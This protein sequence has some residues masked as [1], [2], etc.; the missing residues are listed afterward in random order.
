MPEADQ[1]TSVRTLVFSDLVDSTRLNRLLSDEKWSALVAY[2]DEYTRQLLAH[3]RGEEFNRSDGY[4]MFFPDPLAALRFA[5]AYHGALAKASTHVGLPIKARVGIHHGPVRIKSLKDTPGASTHTQVDGLALSVTA[6]IMGLADGGQ[7][8]MTRA[9]F[10][11]AR[12]LLAAIPKEGVLPQDLQWHAHGEYRLKGLTDQMEVFEAGIPDQAPL[13]APGNTDKGVRVV[14]P[15]EEELLGWRPGPGLALPG[16]NQWI[17]RRKLGQGGFGE[18]W[19]AEHQGLR[20]QHVFKFCFHGERLRGLRREVMLFRALKD[21]LGHQDHVAKVLDWNLEFPPYHVELEYSELGSVAD[22][23]RSLG[24]I[25]RVPLRQRLEVMQDAAEG[26]YA[27]HQAGIIHRD[28]K[29]SNILVMPGPQ[30]SVRGLLSD[31][32]I[33]L[34]EDADELRLRG[35]TVTGTVTPTTG[36]STAGTRMYMAPELDQGAKPSPSTDIYSYGVTLY[37]MVVGDLNRPISHGWEK[38]VESESL[39]EIIT[40]CIDR[41]GQRLVTMLPLLMR[42]KN[43]LAEIRAREAQERSILARLRTVF[44]PIIH[45]YRWVAFL[46]V[47][48]VSLA[49]IDL[50]NYTQGRSSYLSHLWDR[51]FR[52]QLH[53]PGPPITSNQTTPNAAAPATHQATRTPDLQARAVY[54]KVNG[55]RNDAPDCGQRAI[56]CVEINKTGSGRHPVS[57]EFVDNGKPLTRFTGTGDAMINGTF[58]PGAKSSI[59]TVED[60][61]PGVCEICSYGQVVTPISGSNSLEVRVDPTNKLT[62]TNETNNTTAHIYHVP[63]GNYDDIWA[64]GISVEDD[65]LRAQIVVGRKVT[66]EGGLGR[67]F[68]DKL[69]PMNYSLTVNGSA[70]A[71]GS[72]PDRG[73][74]NLSWRVPF[75][76]EREGRYDFVITG[77]H[78][79]GSERNTANNTLKLS[80]LAVPV[81]RVTLASHPAVRTEPSLP[82]PGQ[83]VTIIFNSAASPLRLQPA[84]F[85]H[86]GYNGWN[87]LLLP[88]PSMTRRGPF[89]W[90]YTRALPIEAKVLNIA[91]S[92]HPVDTP[93]ADIWWDNNKGADW[94][95]PVPSSGTQS[96]VTATARP[97]SANRVSLV[98][99]LATLPDG[100]AVNFRSRLVLAATRGDGFFPQFL[101]M[102]DSSGRQIPAVYTL[103]IGRQLAA[104]GTP[105]IPGAEYDISGLRTNYQGSL[106]IGLSQA[107]DIRKTADPQPGWNFPLPR[108]AVTQILDEDL[109]TMARF[110]LRLPATFERTNLRG[111]TYRMPTTDASDGV[112]TIQFAWSTGTDFDLRWRTIQPKPGQVIEVE[113]MI[114]R[115]RGGDLELRPLAPDQLIGVVP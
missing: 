109:G 88:R 15:G 80:V 44:Q 105:L 16:R 82:I 114:R 10:D 34:I 37:Q 63:P 56:A 72:S 107:A 65:P 84:L 25:Q 87:G 110:R 55:E 31:F 8:L 18:V 20:E 12:E 90:A 85:L 98:T 13:S 66:V 93:G 61:G 101:L 40:A 108:K 92:S 60:V 33:G 30:G 75:T 67:S 73:S 4:Q 59:F 11:L 78:A 43:P 14:A 6:R 96:T 70:L 106:Q 102:T 95:I 29:P 77:T 1:S 69:F 115:G 50:R 53:L 45:A 103:D 91:F 54:F 94:N 68:C 23:A 39:R 26:L 22:W 32:G 71:S 17:I 113:G 47:V 76:P 2:L 38:D 99:E 100:T 28:V 48:C 21:K 79:H 36:G 57:V 24:G 27:A 111:L 104:S 52:E 51:W 83:P 7:T 5:M 81:G 58:I 97:S 35:I 42:L 86:S 46:T 74:P 3:F 41:P 112:S 62:E 19:L 9:A 49:L 64:T 89:E